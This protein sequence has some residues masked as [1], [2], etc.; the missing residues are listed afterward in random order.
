MSHVLKNM[1]QADINN[2]QKEPLSEIMWEE[3]EKVSKMYIKDVSILS[4]FTGTLSSQSTHQA[5]EAALKG[6]TEMSHPS[7]RQLFL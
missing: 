6:T 1:A 5:K 2:I 3:G 7:L 4:I